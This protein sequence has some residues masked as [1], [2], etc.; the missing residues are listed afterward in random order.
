VDPA[1]LPV[2]DVVILTTAAVS[3]LIG[4]VRGFV[5]EA[6]SLGVWLAAFV[7][8]NVSA[9][10]ASALFEDWV[11]DPALRFPLAF[12]AVFVATLILGNLFMRVLGMLV[13]ATGLTGLDRT[14]GT[15]FG[16]ARAGVLLVVLVFFAEPLFGDNGWWQASRLVPWLAGAQEETFA[17][18]DR[19]AAAVA[20][21]VSA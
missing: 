13:D 3:V 11:S 8:A 21:W 15:L 20:G 5:R 9:R 2:L 10:E 19:I 12:G 1:E 16:A 7:V 17:L 14:L 4:A 6:V 18:L